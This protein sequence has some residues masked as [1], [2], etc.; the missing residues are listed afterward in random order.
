[1]GVT[2]AAACSA[3]SARDLGARATD[4][5]S[6]R[7]RP[8]D[9]PPRPERQLLDLIVPPEA[10]AAGC[11][12]D[13]EIAVPLRDLGE[14]VTGV[15]RGPQPPAPPRSH[16]AGAASSARPKNSRAECAAPAGA[17]AA[18]RFHRRRRGKAISALG[19]ACATELRAFR[20]LRV[21]KCLTH[22][23]ASEQRRLA[24]DHVQRSAST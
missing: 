14:G 2:L 13:R 8:A 15:R 24:G 21:W 22:G 20:R 6:R 23:N 4:E 18:R 9:S 12:G 7:S 3:T 10:K 1:M 5:A 19:S 17:I 11:G 16:P